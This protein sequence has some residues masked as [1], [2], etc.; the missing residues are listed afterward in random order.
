MNS[1]LTRPAP[2]L[3]KAPF[4]PIH[5]AEPIVSRETRADGSLLLRSGHA[6]KPYMPSL[7]ALFRSAVE[8]RPDRNFILERDASGAWVG[9][10]YA[11]MRKKVDAVA[12]AL[13]ERGLSPERPVMA[14]SGNA[15]EHAA[16]MLACYTAGIPIAP[17]SV[18]YSLQSQ[19]HAKL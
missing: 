17:I 10:T 3:E 18:A 16:L 1:T 6:L 14:L 5:Y 4:R 11:Q 9:L 8:R 15:V 2:A 7:V 19:D 12:Q 13:L